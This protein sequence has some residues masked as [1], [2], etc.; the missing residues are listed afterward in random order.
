MQLIAASM[1]KSAKND[2]RATN[3][4]IV[5]PTSQAMLPTTRRM[6]N[7]SC[8][9]SFG[10]MSAIIA[11][12][13]GPPTSEN[14]PTRAATGNS[15]ANRLTDPNNSALS[16]LATR[17]NRI[18]FRR[19]SRSVSPP[20]TTDPMMP[21]SE[22]SP[23]RMPASVIP[24]LNFAG[25][26]ERKKRKDERAADLVDEVHADDNPEPARELVVEVALRIGHASEKI[27][28][29]HRLSRGDTARLRRRGRSSEAGCFR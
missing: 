4:P 17:P 26:V 20:P 9:C 5:G 11:A 18:S 28:A 6:P 25:D 7:P 27:I 1:T 24:T 10:R 13:A 14:S 16:A 22:S 23:S 15:H 2:V 21:A 29:S 19:P 8:R 12:C 3:P